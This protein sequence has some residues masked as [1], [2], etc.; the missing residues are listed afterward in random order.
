LEELP[1]G[2][3]GRRVCAIIIVFRGEQQAVVRQ[4]PTSGNSVGSMW[5]H[6]PICSKLHALMSV[7]KAA[8]RDNALTGFADVGNSVTA[9]HGRRR[10]CVTTVDHL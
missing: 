4:R 10:G 9:A 7:F 6:L 5:G 2:T 8:G 3:R 1:N